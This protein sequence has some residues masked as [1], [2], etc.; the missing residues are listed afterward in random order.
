LPDNVAGTSQKLRRQSRYVF[1]LRLKDFIA[2]MKFR[3][4]QDK[5]DFVKFYDQVVADV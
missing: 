1:R 3:A 5:D 2:A 4:S